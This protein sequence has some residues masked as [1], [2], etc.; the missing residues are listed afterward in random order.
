[1]DVNGLFVRSEAKESRSASAA[2]R[3]MLS[4]DAGSVQRGTVLETR[5]VGLHVCFLAE[6][7][8]SGRDV[9]P[10]YQCSPSFE[11][12]AAAVIIAGI[13]IATVASAIARASIMT[14][15]LEF[16]KLQQILIVELETVCQSTS[17]ARLLQAYF[18][19]KVLV[20]RFVATIGRAFRSLW[21]RIGH[22]RP[23]QVP[24]G[25][26]FATTPLEER[27]NGRCPLHRSIG[28]PAVTQRGAYSAFRGGNARGPRVDGDSLLLWSRCVEVTAGRIQPPPVSTTLPTRVGARWAMSVLPEPLE[29]VWGQLGVPHS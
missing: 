7:G 3:S 4:H 6:T 25:V 15:P 24:I 1:M 26:E 14:I 8:R 20:S 13:P 19:A 18:T 16:D 28:Y 29:P 23:S 9:A 12:S 10:S 21:R 27:A 5:L 17:T 22:G 2:G 11:P